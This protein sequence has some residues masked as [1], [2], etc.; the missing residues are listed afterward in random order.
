[1]SLALADQTI[2]SLERIV[3]DTLSDYSTV[4]SSNAGNT[5]MTPVDFFTPD[6]I[7]NK[8][9]GIT[10]SHSIVLGQTNPTI[11]MVVT[12]DREGR[13]PSPHNIIP[14]SAP[15]NT[16]TPFLFTESHSDTCAIL[17]A[18]GGNSWF[19]ADLRIFR[20]LDGGVTWCEPQMITQGSPL[21]LPSA[22]PE[23]FGRGKLWGVAWQDFW[24]PDTALIRVNCRISANHGKDWY[25]PQVLSARD[26]N[27]Q[28]SGGQFTGNEVRIYWTGYSWIDSV[29]D[30]AT[31]SGVF[32]ADSIPP[33]IEIVH[34]PDTLSP[35]NRVVQFV[36]HPSDNDTLSE[37]RLQLNWG[38]GNVFTYIMNSDPNGDFSFNFLIPCEAEYRYRIEAEDFWENVGSYP[39]SGW[40]SF[41]TANWDA[42]DPRVIV[43]PSSFSLSV[44]PNPF[45]PVTTISFTVPKAGRVELTV[46]DVTGRRVQVLVDERQNAGQRFALFDGSDLPSGIYFVRLNAGDISQ[47][48][49][50]VLLK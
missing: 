9:I 26:V 5:W 48:R 31:I 14:S 2:L 19:S 36:V 34:V 40:A 47:T 27:M 43:Q 35:V 37:A 3:Q 33:T 23:L 49:K 12:A 42:A 24:N 44:F 13:M 8:D 25:P 17:Q 20:S 38:T 16:T 10:S 21:F 11:L 50:M 15:G 30:Y 1:V 7:H 39:D 28:Y 22:E 6:S 4:Y 46:Y 41:H 45:N 32:T 29:F 18:V